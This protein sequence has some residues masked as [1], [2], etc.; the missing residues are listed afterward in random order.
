MTLD[1]TS[2]W[3]I[4]VNCGGV[5]QIPACIITGEEVRIM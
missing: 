1:E 3:N 5:K 4:L 2:D